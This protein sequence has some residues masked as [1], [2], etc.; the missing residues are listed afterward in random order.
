MALAVAG[1]AA[2]ATT[3][4]AASRPTDVAKVP[5]YWRKHVEPAGIPAAVSAAVNDAR[6]RLLRKVCK[7]PLTGRLTVSA[8]ANANKKIKAKL[9]DALAGAALTGPP[10]LAE[11]EL[12]ASVTLDIAQADV[13]RA[14]KALHAR[15]GGT[16]GVAGADVDQQIAAAGPK[17]LG[18]GGSAPPPDR[19][20]RHLS[21]PTAPPLTRPA[22]P[23]TI[24]ATGKAKRTGPDTAQARLR[25]IRAAERQACSRLAEKARALAITPRTSVKQFAA[26]HAKITADIRAYLRKARVTR[27][28]IGKDNIAEADVEAATEGLWNIV[29]FW[30]AKVPNRIR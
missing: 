19:Y 9:A 10:K 7:L 12:V 5:P 22:W 3:R 15:S 23:A 27:E 17:R 25:A 26:G 11:R 6:R 28:T 21:R 24:R 18:A 8:W 4:S 13:Y 29:K 2:A 30:H 20:L 16:G 14:L 1:A